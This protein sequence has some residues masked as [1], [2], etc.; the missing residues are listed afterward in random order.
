M[1]AVPVGRGGESIAFALRAQQTR[2]TR[3]ALAAAGAAIAAPVFE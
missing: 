1:M 2:E 3:V